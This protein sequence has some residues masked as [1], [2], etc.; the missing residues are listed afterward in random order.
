MQA[1]RMAYYRSPF[2]ECVVLWNELYDCRTGI[3]GDSTFVWGID[4]GF[5]FSCQ[6][7]STS[8]PF[9]FGNNNNYWKSTG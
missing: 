3:L 2:L 1:S 4:R 7:V 6:L 5:N 9:Y 8:Y